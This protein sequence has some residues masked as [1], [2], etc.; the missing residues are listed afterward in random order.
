MN[1]YWLLDESTT[2]AYVCPKLK[3]LEITSL[4]RTI[5]NFNLCIECWMNNLTMNSISEVRLYRQGSGRA[6]TKIS[7]T[8]LAYM[9]KMK[10]VRW[11]IKRNCEYFELSNIIKV[12]LKLFEK[13]Y[14][15]RS[16]TESR[17]RYLKPFYYWILIQVCYE[18]T[19]QNI[20]E[21]CNCRFH[22]KFMTNILSFV[23]NKPI[24]TY[25]SLSMES[26]LSYRI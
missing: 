10:Y 22:S 14:L 11:H 4:R 5:M 8:G 24:W 3:S 13:P 20:I 26:F 12:Y 15:E 16:L 23:N 1:A 18:S 19:L 7:E 6:P 17:K 9:L 25:L 21:Q 2:D